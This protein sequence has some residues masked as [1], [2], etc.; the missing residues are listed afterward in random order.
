MPVMS[1][2]VILAGAGLLLALAMML[3]TLLDNDGWGKR[4]KVQRDL[5][6]INE[7]IRSVQA[8]IDTR[9][10]RIDALRADTTWREQVVRD[11]LGYVRPGDLIVHVAE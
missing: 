10:A 7:Q 6:A 3:H 4:N 5:A 1:R 2:Y 11:E 8:V 9:R